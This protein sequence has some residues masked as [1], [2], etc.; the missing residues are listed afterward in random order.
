MTATA[1]YSVGWSVVLAVLGAG[2][3]LWAIRSR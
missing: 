3:L 2:L 1:G